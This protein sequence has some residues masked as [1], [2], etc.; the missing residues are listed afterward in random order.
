MQWKKNV[1]FNGK[2]P[3]LSSYLFITI[4]G[5][6]QSFKFSGEKSWATNRMMSAKK[7]ML[8]GS[9]NIQI[10]EREIWQRIIGHIQ[11]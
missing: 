8:V 6:L 9:D 1:Q 10:V 4:F 7:K 2:K 11:A 3:H 5:M